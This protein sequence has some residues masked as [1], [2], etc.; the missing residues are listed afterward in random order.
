MSHTLT[1]NVPESVYRSLIQKADEAGQPPEALALQL[2][3]T[4]THPEAGDPVEEFIGAFNSQ[5][6]D[7]ADQHDTH[8]GSVLKETMRG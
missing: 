7:W 8:L 1:L 2:L 3:T 4:A 5:G 6:V